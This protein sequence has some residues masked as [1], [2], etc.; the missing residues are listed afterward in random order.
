MT[1][2][3]IR[4]A[5][6]S[7]GRR[8]RWLLGVGLIALALI[9]LGL[10]LNS[11]GGIDSPGEWLVDNYGNDRK[12]IEIASDAVG[13]TLPVEVLLPKGH[14]KSDGR[15]L[16]VFLHGRGTPPD[17]LSSSAM[18]KALA[19]AGSDAP[20]VA[21]PYGDEASYWHDRAD[22]DWA[23]YVNDEVIPQ[24]SKKF[25]ADDKRLAIGGIS[26]GGFGAFNL[27]RLN[28]GKFCA[29]GGHSPA[30]WLSAGET[31]EGAFDNAED[32]ADNDV[33][34]IARNQPLPFG[35]ARL[36]LDYGDEDPFG[37]GDRAMTAALT[38]SGA[39]FTAKTWPGEHETAYW[40]AHFGDYMRFYT[41]ALSDCDG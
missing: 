33:V 17:R 5:H 14:K 11:R 19:D 8:N 1:E 30:L 2:R 24:V 20:I 25:G 16:L 22:G 28:P 35:S 3:P 6:R 18:L 7:G 31:A 27:A 40:D 41:K 12:R 21:L 36:W 32:F 9:S 15:P 13:K 38:Q 37:A 34:A 23:R 29:V 4:P 10:F 26:M 39:D